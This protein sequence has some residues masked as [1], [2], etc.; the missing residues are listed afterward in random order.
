M[1]Y[2]DTHILVWLYGG[3]VDLLSEKAKTLIESED[4]VIS[5]L[6][7]LELQYLFEIG[8]LQVKPPKLIGSLADEIGVEI[9]SCDLSA[10]I[11][12]SLS[13]MWTRDPFDRLIVAQSKLDKCDLL[14]S[15]RKIRKN[16]HTAKW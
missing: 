7:E 11:R 8:R 13:E 4:L 9:R 12:A 16:V 6:V 14:T 15:D 10:L 3:M 5:P 1:I 2:L